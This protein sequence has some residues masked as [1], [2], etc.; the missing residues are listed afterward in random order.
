MDPK[1]PPRRP[2]APPPQNKRLIVRRPPQPTIPEGDD[3]APTQ[4]LPGK[5]IRDAIEALELPKS[6]P[7]GARPAPRPAAG[8][9]PLGAPR[10]PL[11]VPSARPP[12][13]Q[14]RVAVPRAPAPVPA[15]GRPPAPA[16]A[17]GRPPPSQPKRTS[18]QTSQPAVAPRP[19]S[20]PP[21]SQRSSVRP[22]SPSMFPRAPVPVPTRG[23][24]QVGRLPTSD[25]PP[26]RPL[27]PLIDRDDNER[28][29]IMAERPL[30]GHRQP[31]RAAPQHPSTVM[32]SPQQ[33]QQAAR[34]Q[35]H[36]Q[37]P[38]PFARSRPPGPMM[39]PAPPGVMSR[40]PGPMNYGTPPPPLTQ[41]GPYPAVQ[42]GPHA[43]PGSGPYQSVA[44]PRVSLRAAVLPTRKPSP[45]ADLIMWFVLVGG[46]LAGPAAA[47]LLATM[48]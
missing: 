11:G 29:M 20:Q 14:P 21:A 38:Q 45:G 31:A 6:R 3:D 35:H 41:S 19:S 48:N 22:P 5:E 47:A 39:S 7:P 25:R 30:P 1:G 16:P 13:P 44:P 26:G 46:L 12:A 43:L 36:Q 4:L 18:S 34:M 37:P 8:L 23:Q 42:T 24:S 17:A 2:L 33:H 40:P 27:P 10:P 32:M 15:A 28:T 9:P